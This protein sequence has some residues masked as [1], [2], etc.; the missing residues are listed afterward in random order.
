[1]IISFN[2]GDATLEE[3]F[4]DHTQIIAIAIFLITIFAII[5]ERFDNTV[6]AL[7]GA[8]AIVIFKV[9]PLDDVMSYVSFNTLAVLIGMMLFVA[10]LG[11]TG[12]FEYIAIFTAKACKGSSVKIIFS[13][14]VLTAIF[15]GILDNVTTVLLMGPV[16][17]L[18]TK[19]LKINP[20]PFIIM[21]IF[22]SNVGGTTT[23]IG[24]PP[25]IM[26]GS[27]AGLS[28]SDFIVHLLPVTVVILFITTA[29]IYFMYRRK[30]VIKEEDK[31]EIM[32]LNPKDS[33]KDKKLLYKGL[34]I[35]FFILL[36]FIFGDDLGLSAGVVAIAGASVYLLITRKPI[37]KYINQVEWSAILFFTGLFILV[38]GLESAGIIKMLADLILKFGQHNMIL[39]M[40]I[41]LW[42]SAIVSSFLDN[43]PFVATLIP[44][45]MTLKAQGVDVTML[46]WAISLGACLG[47]NGTLIGASANVVLAKVSE[48]NGYKITFGQYLKVGFPLM[49]LSIIIATGYLLIM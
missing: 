33:L 43:I 30:L 8:V 15:S 34:I 27:A 38:G 35:L 39:L 2:P 45:V 7:L 24:D 31:L 49:I 13:L 10:V 42:L 9:I 22:A 17:F 19:K 20:I 32:K 18:I 21:E 1:M 29:I 4:M 46:W 44:L 5:S 23:L 11:E 26:I 6:L 14:A 47:G 41:L 12:F 48:R 36:G 28:F 37:G 40:L 3:D 16:T 25:N